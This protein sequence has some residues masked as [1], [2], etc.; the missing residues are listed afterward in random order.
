M[1]TINFDGH[2]LAAGTLVS[3]QFDGVE[4]STP[5]E[6][7]VMLFDTNNIT[8]EDSDLA[9]TDLDNVLIISED[10]DSA[11]P[12]D[13]AAGGTIN[14]EFDHLV[15]INSIGL[16]DIDESGSVIS[17]YDENSNLIE[18]V[19]I[20]NLGENSFQQLDLDINNVASLDL[21]LSGSG[22]FTGIDFTS[23]QTADYSNIYI[24][25]DSLSDT[26]NLFN[27]TSFLQDFP[28]TS[29]LGIPVLPPSPPYFEGRFSNGP[30]WIENLADELGIDLAPSSE[31]SVVSPG[32][33]IQS[34]I[35]VI[36]GNPTVSPFFE[37]ES[38]RSINFA[39][40]TATSGQTGTQTP[41]LSTFYGAVATII[42]LPMLIPNR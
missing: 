1:Q 33:N 2:N 19:D 37:G 40:G 6:F 24:F 20:D 35:T 23:N 42:L 12:D 39:Y 5:S 38:D 8:G 41:M 9:S 36:D 14:L 30:I 16:L 28:D 7:G 15:S 13:N 4:F 31:L 25:G 34:P 29:A 22:A 27:T 32:S 3:N 26:G 18:T 10:G 17:F 21:N 11:D